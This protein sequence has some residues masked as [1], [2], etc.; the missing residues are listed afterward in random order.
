M[1]CL[2]YFRPNA[3]L[4]QVGQEFQPVFSRFPV[5]TIS[6]AMLDRLRYYTNDGTYGCTIQKDFPIDYLK[7]L[8]ERQ[9]DIVCLVREENKQAFGEGSRKSSGKG[10]EKRSEKHSKGIVQRVSEKYGVSERTIWKDVSKLKTMGLLKREGG[11]KEGN[12][13]VVAP[14][15][16][17]VKGDINIVNDVIKDVVKELSDRQRFIV[18]MVKNEGGLASEK[19]AEKIAEKEGVSVRTIRRDLS[20]LKANGLLKREGGQKDGYWVV[21]AD[22]NVVIDDIKDDINVVK[23]VPKDDINVVKE[24]TERQSLIYEI[25]IKDGAITASS[26]AERLCVTVRTVQRDLEDLRERGLMVREGGR[27]DGKWIITHKNADT[28]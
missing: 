4:D 9:R 16:N 11:R 1:M 21:V 20:E 3:K 25:M 19:I 26:L 23:D 24:L 6:Q 2:E 15:E 18:D 12:W 5:I 27:K 22:M 14:K 13:V 8:S 10:S 28:D 17:V 7:Q